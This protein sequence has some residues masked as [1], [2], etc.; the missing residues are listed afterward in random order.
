MQSK[1]EPVLNFDNFNL[2][3]H[4]PKKNASEKDDSLIEKDES[5]TKTFQ[6]WAYKIETNLYILSESASFNL[7][8]V[9]KN[10]LWCILYIWLTTQVHRITPSEQWDITGVAPVY[11]IIEQIFLL[12]ITIDFNV[13]FLAARN[14]IK[15]IF[16][17][18]SL[19]DLITMPP[20]EVVV[21]FL[22]PEFAPYYTLYFGWFRFLRLIR[23]ESILSRT[24]PWISEVRRRFLSLV[25]GAVVILLMFSSTIFLL[26]SPAP[27]GYS[28]IFS[29]AFFALVTIS[30]VGYGDF[31][32]ASSI[33]RVATMTAIVC[34]VAF[35][36]SQIQKL[37]ATISAETQMIG[38]LPGDQEDFLLFLGPIYPN[39]LLLLCR[40]LCVSF[41][42]S[43]VNVVVVTP[44][45]V[46]PYRE[47]VKTVLQKG[48]L[49]LCVKHENNPV[50]DKAKTLAQK[51]RAVFIF[52]NL[53]A[54][55][56]LHHNWWEGVEIIQQ[57][58]DL[59]TVVRFLTIQQTCWPHTPVSVQIM[60]ENSQRLLFEL[61]A[62]HVLCVQTMKMSLIAMS[63]SRCPGFLVLVCNWF[64]LTAQEPPKKLKVDRNF[65]DYYNGSKFQIYRLKFPLCFNGHEFSKISR[66]LFLRFGV[67]LIGIAGITKDHWIFP[68]RYIIESIDP[69]LLTS[70][71]IRFAISGILLA[72]SLEVLIE[73]Q[74]LVSVRLPTD[75]PIPSPMPRPRAFTEE[76]EESFVEPSKNYTSPEISCQ[77]EPNYDDQRS[78]RSPP[79][80]NFPPANPCQ[81]QPGRGG[82]GLRRVCCYWRAL[83]KV[84][85]NPYRDLVVVCGWPRGMHVF[86]K[87]LLS[88]S[89]S[90]SAPNIVILSP[91]FPATI[92]ETELSKME[93]FTVWVKGSG[94]IMSDLMKSGI[95]A[96]SSCAIFSTSHVQWRGDITAQKMD[97]QAMI[98]RANILAI[99]QS[100]QVSDLRKDHLN[101]IRQEKGVVNPVKKLGDPTTPHIIIELKRMKNLELFGS[102]GSYKENQS[103]DLNEAYS[104]SRGWARQLEYISASEYH[105]GRVFVEECLHGM[106]AY[107]LPVSR[108]AVDSTIIE[109]LIG[110]TSKDGEQEGLMELIDGEEYVYKSFEY[111]FD[112]M[113]QH[114]RLMP[115]GVYRVSE[116]STTDPVL[117]AQFTNFYVISCPPRS[118]VIQPTDRL[119]CLRRCP[120]PV[121]R[122]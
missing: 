37:I 81:T 50:G 6:R 67:F 40:E 57:E 108:F 111:V 68:D 63:L 116:K 25:T 104:G 28:N 31:A 49:Y 3:N 97:S 62:Y 120:G 115:L 7:V 87:T 19:I 38:F 117:F 121:P 8:I 95:L 16:K 42:S 74:S 90:Y 84:F 11:Y 105:S 106:M 17:V 12:M 47:I 15:F 102:F 71:N 100:D 59:L 54:W 103:G 79:D 4:S 10:V 101:K 96:A 98:V 13:S 80:Q 64:F 118:L 35:L 75:T 33:G 18:Y 70:K 83:E 2:G 51:A 52:G 21:S 41:P 56:E 9:L 86:L 76:S 77:C 45:A 34:T 94:L 65:E 91:T 60:Q 26:E 32:P 112:T 55:D 22:A 61:G 99:F 122:R 23:V 88:V 53:R 110:G 48:G 89:T 44:G 69:N 66:F 109:H 24:V 107:T 29:F 20:A 58:D 43:C 14:K 27:S 78:G 85:K 113:V 1:S 30:T 114:T 39:Q 46:E 82:G 73:I 36:P 92:S 5:C 93:S 72:P 119:Y